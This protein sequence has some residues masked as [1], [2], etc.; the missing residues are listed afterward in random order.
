MSEIL[1][2][3][4]NLIGKFGTG[5]EL[6]DTLEQQFAVGGAPAVVVRSPIGTTR[7]EA[8]GD[9]QV[10]VTAVRRMRGIT[11]EVAPGSLDDI[12]VEMTQSGDTVRVEVH[13]KNQ[14][15]NR[16]PRV[17]LVLRVPPAATLDV[18]QNAGNVEIIGVQSR[19]LAKLDAGNLQVS[20]TRGLLQATLSAGNVEANDVTLGDGSRLTVSA[21]RLVISGGLDRGAGVSIRVDAGRAKLSL[22]A[23]T[24]ARLEATAEVGS[25]SVSGW[26]V[27]I[28][29]NVTSARANG[30]LGGGVGGAGTLAIHVG[31]GDIILAAT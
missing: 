21:G 25:I 29:R 18:A 14:L 27:P 16:V 9:G 31:V 11:T 19:V 28:A 17:D 8:A 2:G 20:G 13:L 4:G 5:P 6:T 12:Q 22:P 7:V 15:S 1:K 26:S 3:L 23:S 30:D 10:M 24:A